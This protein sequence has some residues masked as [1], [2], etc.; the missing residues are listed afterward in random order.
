MA[1]CIGYGNQ[2]EEVYVN[3]LDTSSYLTLPYLT[4]PHLTSPHL[5]S[6]HQPLPGATRRSTQRTVESG[7]AIYEP[8]S[9]AAS[10]GK[11]LDRTR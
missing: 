1:I 3:R 9:E 2:G 4:L 8:C 5:T 11:C 7:I 10:D 6:P